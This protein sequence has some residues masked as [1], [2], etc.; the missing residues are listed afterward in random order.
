MTAACRWRA[1]TRAAFS[2]S[3]SIGSIARCTGAAGRGR[4]RQ[5]RF[6]QLAEDL[7]PLGVVGHG[8]HVR[9]GEHELRAV[10]S[11]GLE[12]AREALEHTDRVLHRVPARNLHDERSVPR[13]RTRPRRTTSASRATRL[14][15]PSSRTKVGDAGPGGPSTRPAWTRIARIVGSSI[16]R[17]F[18][19][20]GSIVGGRHD[21]AL[22]VQ[23]GGRIGGARED[24]DRELLEVRAEE[25]PSRGRLPRR[26][27]R[28]RCGSATRPERPW[29]G[30]A[31][32]GP[33]SAGRGRRRCRPL[34]R[35]RRER[36]RSRLV[37][38]S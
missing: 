8:V 18:A 5:P 27:G 25:T 15:L 30:S 7:R 22:A 14:E 32:R 13:R 10:R 20:N 33:R 35:A 16:G 28:G 23:P 24:R 19:E 12:E 2:S 26:V 34:S 3:S 21:R 29:R 38:R 1:L 11:V 9:S 4:E 17:F 37:T 36:R 31:G 6:L